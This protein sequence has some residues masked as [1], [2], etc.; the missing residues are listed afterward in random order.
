MS[1][2]KIGYYAVCPDC[3]LRI[4]LSRWKWLAVCGLRF[5]KDT[6]LPTCAT[7]LELIYVSEEDL[8]DTSE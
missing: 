3:G 8:C 6:G 4:W 7:P 1:T 5:Y 2:M